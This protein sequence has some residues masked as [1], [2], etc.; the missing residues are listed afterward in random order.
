MACSNPKGVA[1]A[2]LILQDPYA[3]VDI[4]TEV[5]IVLWPKY[6]NLKQ[7]GNT[8]LH[9]A[10]QNLEPS[11]EMYNILERLMSKMEDMKRDNKVCP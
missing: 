6:N 1:I 10:F 2:N 9:Y 4:K 11:R 8:A 7:V 3:D 5:S